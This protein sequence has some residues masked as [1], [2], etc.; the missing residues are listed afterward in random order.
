MEPT[1]E[2]ITREINRGMWSTGY[3]GQSPERLK[4]HMANQDKFD[5]V[6]LRAL[7][8]APAEIAGRF[9]RPAL[10]LLGHTRTAAPRDAY[11]VQHQ[12]DPMKG[13][14]AFRPRFGLDREGETLLAEGSWPV[15]SEIE[16]GYPEFTYG[17]LQKLGWDAD[18]T[19]RNWR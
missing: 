2:S 1:P 11:P 3:T 8:D 17:V 15:G 10:A 13:G 4:A 19:P 16:D 14:G 12:P 6:T 5:L 9:L 18:L 7:P